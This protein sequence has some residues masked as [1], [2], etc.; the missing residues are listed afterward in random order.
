MI[1]V[2]YPGRSNKWF[3][4]P[5][6]RV[7]EATNQGSI[8]VTGAD[9]TIPGML[10]RPWRCPTDQRLGPGES[11]ELFP[12]IYG[13]YPLTFDDGN[14][15]FAGDATIVLHFKDDSGGTNVTTVTAPIVAGDLPTTY[16]GGSGTWRDPCSP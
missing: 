7:A 11:R 5:Q 10:P 9:L 12:E 8:V 3:Y 14:R 1:E 15:R 16:S 4:A 6:I 2:Q 13:D